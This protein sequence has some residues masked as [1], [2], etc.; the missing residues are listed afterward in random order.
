[1]VPKYAFDD[2]I[3]FAR[4]L[5]TANKTEKIDDV[6][7]HWRS[8]EPLNDE[9]NEK[10][11][12]II[13]LRHPLA[14]FWRR[15]VVRRYLHTFTKLFM[16]P[17]SLDE[18]F[19]RVFQSIDSDGITPLN[20]NSLLEI[21]PDIVTPRTLIGYKDFAEDLLPKELRH[22]RVQTNV[23]FWR[24]TT[25]SMYDDNTVP[26]HSLQLDTTLDELVILLKQVI[27]MYRTADKLP[28]RSSHWAVKAAYAL[29][30]E[31]PEGM[32][33][34]GEADTG[35]MDTEFEDNKDEDIECKT[36]PS[37]LSPPLFTSSIGY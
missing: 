37:T 5:K 20:L 25:F 15:S 12:T 36:P 7:R 6:I 23:A 27:V 22:E 34:L 35:D 26:S 28:E 13:V 24:G 14:M 4:V 9:W 16:Y 8:D 30:L 11:T 10:H 2:V 32:K 33:Y 17:K 29:R 21:Q 3:A 1:M 31:G 18:C 19:H